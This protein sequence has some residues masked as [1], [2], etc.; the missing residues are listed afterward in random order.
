MRVAL[1]ETAIITLS[2]VGSGIAKVGPQSARET[3]YPQNVSVNA[4]SGPVN[5][6]QCAILV[7]DAYTRQQRDVTVNGSSGDS[8]DKCNGDRIRCGEYIWAVWSGGDANVSATLTVT[9][10]KEI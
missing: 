6:S 9:G 1:R 5:E 7:G 2:G 10:E 8:T 3:W 4:N